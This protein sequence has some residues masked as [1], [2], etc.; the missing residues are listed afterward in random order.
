[1][2][3]HEKKARSVQYAAQTITDADYAVDLALLANTSTQ[4]ESLAA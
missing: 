4:A 3:L 2:V 1:M